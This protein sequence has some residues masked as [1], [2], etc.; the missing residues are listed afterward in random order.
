MI[1][2]A[3]NK[4]RNRHKQMSYDWDNPFEIIE[5]NKTQRWDFEVSLYL[6]PWN[7]H[8]YFGNNPDYGQC[9]KVVNKYKKER[10]FIENWMSKQKGPPKVFPHQAIF[11]AKNGYL[12]K[13]ECFKQGNNNNHNQNRNRNHNRNYSDHKM[14]IDDNSEQEES[15]RAKRLKKRKEKSDE[16]YEKYQLFYKKQ[17]G[18]NKQQQQRSNTNTSDTTV[19]SHICGWKW[20]ISISHI[21]P[22]CL[23]YNRER[24]TCHQYLDSIAAKIRKERQKQL[25]YKYYWSENRLTYLRF[26][27]IPQK[28]ITNESRICQ[29]EPKCFRNYVCNDEVIYY[30]PKTL[31]DP[32]ELENGVIM[33]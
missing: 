30:Q 22:E 10:L 6:E 1:N 27:D 11:A 20:C 14:E 26:R 9:I 29:H 32:H 2:N 7:N 18:Q 12:P 24:W 17:K 31:I 13:Y 19:L 23:K 8:K 4:N 33:E 5:Y 21:K 28:Y 16:N 15:E 3:H 25:G